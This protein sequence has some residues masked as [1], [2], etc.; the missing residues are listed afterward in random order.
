MQF[1]KTD[2][3]F[4]KIHI[5]Q[6][7]IDRAASILVKF[8]TIEKNLDESKKM[9]IDLQKELSLLTKMFLY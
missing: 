4:F 7:E 6:E 9:L 3:N 1:E 8:N 5:S 2:N